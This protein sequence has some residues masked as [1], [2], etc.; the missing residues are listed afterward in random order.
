MVAG[1]IKVLVFFN[2]WVRGV[3]IF[4]GESLDVIVRFW[5]Q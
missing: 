2:G 5:N 1:L 4:L 3:Q